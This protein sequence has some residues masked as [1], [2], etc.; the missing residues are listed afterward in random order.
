MK[1]ELPLFDLKYDKIAE[2]I[3]HTLELLDNK[4]VYHFEC[5]MDKYPDEEDESNGWLLPKEGVYQ[6]I[7]LRVRRERIYS[8]ESSWLEDSQLW[9]LVLTYLGVDEHIRIKFKTEKELREVE[10]AIDRWLFTS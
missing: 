1:I 10:S 8:I 3:A 7:W 6:N 4:I 5:Y 9:V 2:P